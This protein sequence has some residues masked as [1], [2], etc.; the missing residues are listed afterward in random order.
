[1]PAAKP[2]PRGLP[3][4]TIGQKVNLMV[5]LSSTFQN[6]PAPFVK[7]MPKARD[8]WRRYILPAGFNIAREGAGFIYGN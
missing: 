2:V 8:E 5:Y 7:D 4:A 1:M 3:T 6:T